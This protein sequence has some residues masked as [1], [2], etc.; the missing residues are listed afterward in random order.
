MATSPADSGHEW[1]GL[2]EAGHYANV[3]P[4]VL[5]GAI[6]AG[7]LDAYEKPVTR[8]RRE[9]ATRRNVMLRVSRKDI[10]RYI[11]SHWRKADASTFGMPDAAGEIGGAW[12]A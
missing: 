2:V 6:I 11:R 7:E 4:D 3:S 10:D 9:G 5:K 8:G 1:M 12:C